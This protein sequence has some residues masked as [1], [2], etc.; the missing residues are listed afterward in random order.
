MIFFS[1]LL[2]FALLASQFFLVVKWLHIIIFVSLGEPYLKI[3]S[4]ESK[5][6]AA[7]WGPLDEYI[8]TGHDNGSIVKWNAKVKRHLIIILACI[9]FILTIYIFLLLVSPGLKSKIITVKNNNTKK[10]QD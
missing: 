3:L 7:V 8:L 9:C 1:N 2:K 5:V 6:T 4:E 10:S